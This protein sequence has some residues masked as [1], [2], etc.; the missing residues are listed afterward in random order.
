MKC[1]HSVPSNEMA[2]LIKSPQELKNKF[3]LTLFQNDSARVVLNGASFV[4]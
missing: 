1:G 3:S 2:Y 4:K